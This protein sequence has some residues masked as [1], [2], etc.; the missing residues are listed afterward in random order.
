MRRNKYSSGKFVFDTAEN[1]ASGMRYKGLSFHLSLA[2]IP[3]FQPSLHC[4]A[5]CFCFSTSEAFIKN[6]AARKHFGVAL[7]LSS[8]L[9]I[10]FQSVGGVMR[11]N[12]L[13]TKFS[14]LMHRS[15]NM[16]ANFR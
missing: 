6:F 9:I 16:S 10:D 8:S 11:E 1:E 5:G 14:S 12:S 3:Y 4:Y 7:L 2:W 15:I 13:V